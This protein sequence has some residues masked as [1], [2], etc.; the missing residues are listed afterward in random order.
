MATVERPMASENRAPYITRLRMSRPNRSQ[1]NQ[2][3]ADIGARRRH[4]LVAFQS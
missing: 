3:W 4:W 1:P 2:C